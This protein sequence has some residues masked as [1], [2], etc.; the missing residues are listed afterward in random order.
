MNKIIKNRI[1]NKK[2]KLM[3]IYQLKIYNIKKMI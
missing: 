1:N 3:K 2:Y